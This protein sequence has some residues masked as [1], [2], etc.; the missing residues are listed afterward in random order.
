LSKA[1]N[2]RKSRRKSSKFYRDEQQRQ[3]KHKSKIEGAYLIGDITKI[4]K[5]HF[6]NFPQQLASIQDPR[7]QQHY[8]IDEIIFGAVSMFL[9]KSGSRNNYDNFRNTGAFEKNFKRTFGFRLPSMDA[10][11]DVMKLLDEAEL[12]SLKK[13]M[14]KALINKKVFWKM[15]LQGKYLIA[16]DATGISSYKE[17]HCDDCLYTESKNGV[18]TYYHKV[19]EAKIVTA[20]GFSVS[21]CTEWIDN[22]DTNDGKYDKQG[23]EN[24]AFKKLAVKLKKEYPRL[25]ICICA[26]GL[27][28]HNTFFEICKHNRWDYIVTL[29]DGNLK[30]FWEKIRLMNRECRIHN[31]VEAETKT[32]QLIQWLNSIE[33][34]GFVHNWMKCEERK[35]TQKKVVNKQQFVYLTNLAIDYDN[36]I[37]ISNSGRLRWK[38]EKQGFDQQKNHG[39]NIQ[40]KYCRKSYTGMKNFY[41]CCQIAHIINQLVELSNDFKKILKRKIS[42]RFLWEMMRGFM[43][44]NHVARTVIAKITAHRYQIQ[45]NDY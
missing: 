12:E 5:H 42:I 2:A 41:Q 34:N 21:I 15:R 23:C 38:I 1:R 20:N 24:K 11:A 27:Y 3:K 13:E 14:I 6:P 44:Y 18:K 31:T 17:K 37:S 19:L 9:F 28:P 16:V 10:V 39:Y 35:T 4:I 33:H 36:C 8:S 43:V 7:K 29:K 26:D 32:H 40:H 22:K 45:Y 30:G 25:P